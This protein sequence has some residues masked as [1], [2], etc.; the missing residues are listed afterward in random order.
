MEL[1]SGGFEKKL[2][3]PYSPLYILLPYI[4]DT[5]PSHVRTS[6]RTTKYKTPD[7]KPVT[8][9]RMISQHFQRS[10]PTDLI[11]RHKNSSA[12]YES[13]RHSDLPTLADSEQIHRLSPNLL[14]SH[15]VS[16]F[17][18]HFS[19]RLQA[20]RFSRPSPSRRFVRNIEA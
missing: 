15:L 6:H 8:F 11:H 3:D 9:S 4:P 2:F 19:Q 18:N 5:A 13:T 20:F 1:S 17:Q 10:A 14:L 12:V 7:S 16:I